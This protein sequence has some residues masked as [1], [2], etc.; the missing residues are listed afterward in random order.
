MDPINLMISD[1]GPVKDMSLDVLR[2]E[3]VVI[4]QKESAY[5]H[6][7]QGH[8]NLAAGGAQPDDS[9]R[10]GRKPGILIRPPGGSRSALGAHQAQLERAIIIEHD[11]EMG[12]VC[13]V[14]DEHAKRPPVRSCRIG[15]RAAVLIEDAQGASLLRKDISEPGE[16]VYPAHEGRV[17]PGFKENA[18]LQETIVATAH[19]GGN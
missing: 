3:E 19:A 8:R 4:D 5:A 10:P 7:R 9:P 11:E 2:K 1:M 6:A 15:L 17:E 16:P 13:P 18:S 12:S 14:Y